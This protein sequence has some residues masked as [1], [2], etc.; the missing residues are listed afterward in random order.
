MNR[1]QSVRKRVET[2][3]T[4][5][6]DAK[7]LMAMVDTLRSQILETRKSLVGLED[8]IFRPIGYDKSE[9]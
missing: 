2:G 1:L 5:Q 3:R 9:A 4:T 7:F 6:D 8:A